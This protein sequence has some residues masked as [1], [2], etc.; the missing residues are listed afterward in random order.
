MIYQSVRTQEVWQHCNSI[1]AA[2]WI[3]P[4]EKGAALDTAAYVHIVACTGGK[5]QW[6][7][8]TSG[9]SSFRFPLRLILAP[10]RFWHLVSDSSR[11]GVS[12]WRIPAVASIFMI[13][14]P[15]VSLIGTDSR[16][17]MLPEP[18]FMKNAHGGS[19][20]YFW[21]FLSPQSPSEPKAGSWL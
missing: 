20:F 10:S 15:L 16:C 9:I 18:Q 17:R 2:R 7:L 6:R 12:F 11:Y 5:L 21:K 8:P 1:T 3:Q 13:L 14:D 4:I 19:D